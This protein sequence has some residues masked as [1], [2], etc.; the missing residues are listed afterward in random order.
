MS[1]KTLNRKIVAGAA[2]LSLGIVAAV[3]GAHPA[4]ADAR[5]TMPSAET[6]QAGG[7][8]QMSFDIPA[9]P[10]AASLMA[11]G[12]RTGLQVLYPTQVARDLRAKAVVGTMTVNEAL[13]RMLVGTG[14]AYRFSAADTVTVALPGQSEN[15]ERI[16][17]GTVSVEGRA[18]PKQAEI[19]NLPPAYAGGQVA[20]GGKLGM[21]GNRDMMDTP[22]NQSTYTAQIIEDQQ[23]RT[24]R[25]VV[26]NDPAVRATWPGT[27]YT[28]PLVIRGFQAGN[29]DVAFGGLYGVAPTFNVGLGLAERVEILKGPSALLGGM[30]PLGSVGGTVNIVPKRAGQEPVTK[31]T[32]TYAGT[33]QFGG[34]TDV[35]R[36]FGNDGE[37]GVR[38]NA[39]LEDGD[40]AVDDQS[41]TYAT[42]FAALDYQADRFR[43]SAD[44]G[45]QLQNINAPTLLT[46]VT[47]SLA[48]PETPD[49]S[50]NWFMPWGWVDSED[51]FGAGRAEFDLTPEWTA[52][53][54]V[55]AKRAYWGRLTYFPTVTNLDGDLSGTPNHQEYV[56]D[57]NTQEAGVR[58]SL[59]TAGIG[60]ELSLA[61][62]RFSR[63]QKNGSENI[64]S[65][66]TSNMYSPTASAT[67][68]TS[69]IATPKTAD[70]KFVSLAF[71]DVISAYDKRLQLILGA[72]LQ[73]LKA[74]NYS[75]STGEITSSY[76]QNALSPAV[77][78]IGKPWSNIS[79]YGNYIEGLQQGAVVGSTYANAGENLPPYISKQ[80][81]AGVKIDWGNLGATLSLFEIKQ[82]SAAADNS[83]NLTADGEQRNRGVELAVF[84]KLRED[85]RVLGGMSL[86]DATLTATADGANNGNNAPGVPKIQINMGL[87]WDTPFVTGLTLSG[88]AT[89]TGEQ[90][91]DNANNQSI[92]AWTRFDVGLRYRIDRKG[93][94]PFTVRLNVDNLLDRNYWA[95]SYYPGYISPGAPRTV[96][97]S[98]SSDF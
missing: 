88:R 44:L 62:T 47:A 1:G 67:P 31:V 97:L 94:H 11:L 12:E 76:S 90:H 10:L 95:S 48:V 53:A 58:G 41:R 63:T 45:Y 3:P 50:S 37:F 57:T 25:D 33:T 7:D 19:G 93:L 23:A 35:G 40:T 29:Q 46:F 6:A 54:A 77:A 79:V 74:N 21:L 36:R 55:G 24:V 66:V 84:G 59:E 81:E 92:A 14:L 87:E 49:A 27:G 15:G 43:L 26:A 51:Y 71:G 64:G 30:Q 72:R 98:L 52:Y 38:L 69:D 91:I 8:G 4:R 32:G 70:S 20:R 96:R 17:L 5:Q 78:I 34:L 18:T 61:A 2:L 68:A 80:I 13:T 56:W 82:P 60:H 75:A 73:K 83:N 9:G 65:A 16:T 85:L 86:T 28:D 42:T 22:F 89:Y 39:S